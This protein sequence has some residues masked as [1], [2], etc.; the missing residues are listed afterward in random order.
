MNGFEKEINEYIWS[1]S[2]KYC[3]VIMH[4]ENFDRVKVPS[5]SKSQT[6]K[7]VSGRLIR[8]KVTDESGSRFEKSVHWSRAFDL[9][10]TLW[11][12]PL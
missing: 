3:K 9:S 1:T 2:Q 11:Y 10:R 8:V 6:E 12:L 4:T 7:Y 5:V